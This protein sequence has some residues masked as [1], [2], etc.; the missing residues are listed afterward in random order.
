MPKRQNSDKKNAMHING[1]SSK[2][3][4]LSFC[5]TTPPYKKGVNSSFY[6]GGHRGAYDKIAKKNFPM[7]SMA[8]L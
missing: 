7:K 3:T 5:Q 1:L 2:K 4:V 8:E 6:R